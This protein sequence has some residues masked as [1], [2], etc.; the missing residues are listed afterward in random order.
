[1]RFGGGPLGEA[2][3][4]PLPAGAQGPRQDAADEGGRLSRARPGLQDER[5]V[6]PRLGGPAGLAVLL[7][8]DPRAEIAHQG[9]GSASR[10]TTRSTTP[11]LSSLPGFSHRRQ[12][13]SSASSARLDPGASEALSLHSKRRRRAPESPRRQ[14]SATEQKPQRPGSS[15][16]LGSTTRGKKAPA[17]QASSTE[18]AVFSKA[19][20]S[21]SSP[22][23]TACSLCSPSRS[24]RRKR[25]RPRLASCEPRR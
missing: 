10:S 23:E 25:Y 11:V 4:R 3:R 5:P 8:Q 21:S 14:A 6:E 7:A 9:Q 13:R 20:T 16:P 22:R 1:E 15:R 18:A 2:L 19:L 24:G 12:T 17:L